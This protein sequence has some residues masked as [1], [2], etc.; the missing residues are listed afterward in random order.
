MNDE[1]K[2]NDSYRRILATAHK[3][4][5]IQS[6][7]ESVIDFFSTPIVKLYSKLCEDCM[8]LLFETEFK[9]DL[10]R[11]VEELLWRRIYYDIYRFQKTN[12]QKIKRQD[13][14]LIESHFVSGIGFY[15]TFIVKLRSYYNI[16]D[17]KGLVSPFNL[18]LGPIDNFAA[19]KRLNDDLCSPVSAIN[20]G[21]TK[22]DGP[23]GS[24]RA[25]PAKTWAG[26]AIYRSLVYIG[27][28]SRYL[29]ETSQYDYRKLA[30]DFYLSAS[31]NQPHYGL[32]YNQLA[33]LAGN[34]NNNL[35][36]VCN[37]MRCCLRQKP[38]ERAEGN[39]RSLFDLN[40]GFHEAMKNKNSI[41]TVSEVFSS[42]EPS[43]AAELMVQR[44]TVVFI[45][46]TADLW[47]AITTGKMDGSL[48]KQI[49]EETKTFFEGL[50]EALELEPIVPLAHDQTYTHEFEPI[51]DGS[52]SN[53]R[54][55]YI[56]PSIM[57]EYC[58][59]SIML[60]AKLQGRQQSGDATKL[61][62]N[63]LADLVHALALN[64][65]YYST[66]KCQKMIILKLQE[67]RINLADQ[68]CHD[69][70]RPKERSL[71][72]WTKRLDD[73]IHSSALT[74]GRKSLSRL[75]QREAASNYLD[76]SKVVIAQNEDS[77]MSELEE[78]ALSTIDALEISSD[79]SEEA[80]R[81]VNDLIDLASNSGD[82]S[83]SV[84]EG[85]L[86]GQSLKNLNTCVGD[87]S[88]SF[89]RPTRSQ[90]YEIHSTRSDH[91]Y[92]STSSLPIQDLITGDVCKRPESKST[93]KFSRSPFNCMNSDQDPKE[94]YSP[95]S[96]SE[97]TEVSSQAASDIDQVYAFVYRQ[98]YLPMIK[99]FCDWLLSNG[100]IIGINL[101]SFRAFCTE[102]KTLDSLLDDLKEVAQSKCASNAHSAANSE[103]FNCTFTSD[104]ADGHDVDDEDLFA[105]H[106]F[107]GPNWKQKYPL[108][109]DYPLLDL[110]PVQ[111]THKMNIDFD[112]RRELTDPESGFVS[113]Q[114]V[115]A[116]CHALS[117]FLNNKDS[118]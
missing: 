35:D 58:S 102:L 85:A 73:N 94:R 69:S 113:I 74:T 62:N 93:M 116:F 63:D 67:L 104:E 105:N 98:T 15:S 40:Q 6:N 87:L 91:L 78:T 50:R 27:D 99:V 1:T 111:S 56:T 57:Y 23:I 108:S 29:L 25:A 37:Y 66:S 55:R 95:A 64:L 48:M 26:L 103:T 79:M 76:K 77:D 109:C 61:K 81:H 5:A 114:C 13:E 110:E 39:M 20:P 82:E 12:K 80:D 19:D 60:I 33:T 65:L 2:K 3:L 18:T 7:L 100:H 41:M 21:F 89:L 4:E 16:N 118:V 42:K 28:L 90:N 72:T 70:T 8:K 14:L 22:A 112:S 36:A 45:K 101:P 11:K 44:V 38:F 10:Y 34:Q 86:Y 9:L 17:V 84:T 30:Y 47:S 71:N 51:S 115:K 49:A 106:C 32:P 92:G 54:P 75:R 52:L 43:L 59:V 31:R 24:D 68:S 53:E 107:K 46:L 88:R 97:N 117:T 96:S 83:S